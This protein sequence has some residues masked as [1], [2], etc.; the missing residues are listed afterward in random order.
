MSQPARIY[1]RIRQSCYLAAVWWTGMGDREWRREGGIVSSKFVILPP[2][3]AKETYDPS[4][5]SPE[6]V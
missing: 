3:A 6:N 1:D 2:C 4:E 5:R